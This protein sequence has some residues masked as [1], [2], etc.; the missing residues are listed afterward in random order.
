MLIFWREN[1]KYLSFVSIFRVKAMIDEVGRIVG[2][3]YHVILKLKLD[4][5]IEGKGPNIP[6]EIVV[7]YCKDLL[8]IITTL[9]GDLSHIKGK[10]ALK[11][12]QTQC[13]I[14]KK[15]FSQNILSKE[16]FFKNIKPYFQLQ[17]EAKKLLQF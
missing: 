5:I 15:Q 9:D 12:A 8:P 6:E 1:S 10:V 4:V 11:L 3:N 14:Y 13:E 16:E 7:Q 2:P 17:V